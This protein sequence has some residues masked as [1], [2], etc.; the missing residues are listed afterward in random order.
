[1]F[2]KEE[3]IILG[4]MLAI[5]NAVLILAIVLLLSDGTVSYAKV[6]A[7]DDGIYSTVYEYKDGL[8]KGDM[9]NIVRHGEHASNMGR[10]FDGYFWLPSDSWYPENTELYFTQAVRVETSSVE[11]ERP[12]GYFEPPTLSKTDY[13]PPK[14]KK[15]K[16]KHKGKKKYVHGKKVYY[17]DYII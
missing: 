13:V 12:V 1:M 3:R 11:D 7:F 15:H 10:I 17:V 5:F 14:V 16:H 8:I 4:A 2:K 6:R 9:S